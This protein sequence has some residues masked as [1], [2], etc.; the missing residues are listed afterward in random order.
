M[1]AQEPDILEYEGKQ[2]D[3]IA[4]PLEQYFAPDRSR[5]NFVPESTS[6]WRGYFAEWEI[7]ADRLYLTGLSGNICVKPT[8]P[9]GRT[10][11]WCQG[12]HLGECDIHATSLES[13]LGVNP[14]RIFSD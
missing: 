7:Q 12:G 4:N 2:F 8:E 14:E 10:S 3:I 1:T 6:N 5:P 13:I 9:G 11:S